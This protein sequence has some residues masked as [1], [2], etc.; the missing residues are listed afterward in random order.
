MVEL[1]KNS[2]LNNNTFKLF[3]ISDKPLSWDDTPNN[4]KMNI[5]QDD[6]IGVFSSVIIHKSLY[7][8][9]LGTDVNSQVYCNKLLSIIN[10]SIQTL[11]TMLNSLIPN[12]EY[13][14]GYIHNLNILGQQ[15]QVV[16]VN[17][18]HYIQIN[19]DTN[20]IIV[21]KINAKKEINILIN[22]LK[23]LYSYYA[24]RA[25]EC[26]FLG[27]NILTPDHYIVE[28]I[29]LINYDSNSFKLHFMNNVE[30]YQW[31]IPT[32]K[33]LDYD[34]KYSDPFEKY[35]KNINNMDKLIEKKD[36]MHI[37]KI[38]A[39]L[40]L[41]RFLSINNIFE[42]EDIHQIKTALMGGDDI[43]TTGELGKTYRFQNIDGVNADNNANE[44]SIS[45]DIFNPMQYVYND[46]VVMEKLNIK[47]D[48]NAFLFGDN[49]YITSKISQIIDSDD[50]YNI[51]RINV[52]CECVVTGNDFNDVQKYKTYKTIKFNNGEKR[53]YYY[54]NADGGK[55]YEIL[56]DKGVL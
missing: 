34:I 12:K 41:Y 18:Q 6:I 19:S 28:L 40:I 9:D 25:K 44:I 7:N 56:F 54:D 53:S 32:I 3:P 43:N 4:N 47:S 22:I 39:K 27:G 30:K 21:P 35:F 52:K 37:M 13:Y 46:K 16:N 20:G 38:L 8:N 5:F 24:P 36:H 49:E 48:E 31:V 42:I 14:N 10:F 50:R 55:C 26:E 33:K 1:L 23:E 11:E 29:K 17:H 15:H 2:E 45:K 51:R